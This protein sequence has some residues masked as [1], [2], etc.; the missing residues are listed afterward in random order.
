[1][2]H[3]VQWSCVVSMPLI[4][5]SSAAVKQRGWTEQ[6]EVEICQLFER[7][8]HS[9]G[10][11]C[12]NAVNNY[13][14]VLHIIRCLFMWLY[15][16][17]ILT[18]L[19]RYCSNSCVKYGCLVCCCQH[20]QLVVPELFQSL[21]STCFLS[22]ELYISVL[23]I[24]FVNSFDCWLIIVCHCTDIVGDMMNNLSI[25]RSRKIVVDKL[26][27][28]GLVG[29]RRDLRKKRQRKGGTN[30][31]RQQRKSGNE[32]RELSDV[33]SDEHSSSDGTC[34][35]SHE[36]LLNCI[37]CAVLTV[38]CCC[39][40]FV[41]F[42]VILWKFDFNCQSCIWTCKY[43]WWFRQ[44]TVSD[45]DIYKSSLISLMTYRVYC[46]SASEYCVCTAYMLEW[47]SRSLVEWCKQ[48]WHA[49]IWYFHI[50]PQYF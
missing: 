36:T 14:F 15:L 12:D 42:I 17:V 6:Q 7:F 37:P 20:D 40:L 11:L 25:S 44:W 27:E 10:W 45:S 1:M 49:L 48:V 19:C 50:M 43:V 4:N 28:L 39:V 18:A 21:L 2:Q 33:V 22:I 38:L 29:D 24:M 32:L 9:D 16:L 23:W 26:L 46:C 31:N 5:R 41:S 47:L 8:Q 13:D 30:K 3:S 35:L 34:Y